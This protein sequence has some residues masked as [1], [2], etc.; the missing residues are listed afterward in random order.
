MHVRLHS[1]VVSGLATVMQGSMHISVRS[2]RMLDDVLTP[3]HLRLRL[4]DTGEPEAV[5]LNVLVTDEAGSDY[6]R[7]FSSNYRDVPHAYSPFWPLAS[8]GEILLP[9]M[10]SSFLA[11]LDCASRSRSTNVLEGI[12][13][14][15]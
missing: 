5:A 6:K 14:V 15:T 7:N 1:V 8:L 3:L 11:L 2:K 4:C 13:R 10:R 12:G 9:W